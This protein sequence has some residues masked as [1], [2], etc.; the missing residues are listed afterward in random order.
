MIWPRTRQIF[1]SFRRRP[2]RLTIMQTDYK[3]IP[4]RSPV[5]SRTQ[6]KDSIAI[7]L[8]VAN[9]LQ[10]CPYSPRGEAKHRH[11]RV[12]INGVGDSVGAKAPEART[13]VRMLSVSR[14]CY[15]ASGAPRTRLTLVAAHYSSRGDDG[16]DADA[17]P[18]GDG[19]GE[20]SRFSSRLWAPSPNERRLLVARQ[21][22]SEP[23]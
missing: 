6:A 17:V 5:S 22:G 19:D 9:P 13:I 16:D 7:S 10:L 2:Y 23:V 14:R 18:D 21:R 20:P 1:P 3:P 11:W 4:V 12:S 15:E 8:D